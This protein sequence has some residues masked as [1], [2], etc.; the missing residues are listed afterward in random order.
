MPGAATW[1]VRLATQE[2]RFGLVFLLVGFIAVFLSPMGFLAQVLMG[3]PIFEEAM[4]FGLAVLLT[5]HPAARTLWLRLPVAW[6]VGAGFGVMEHYLTYPSEPD[7][8]F[9]ERCAFHGLSTGASVV[10]HR[11]LVG[12]PEPALRW[13]STIPSVVLHYLNNLAAVVIGLSTLIEGGGEAEVL[14]RSAWLPF[15]ILPPLAALHLV[16]P[17]ARRPMAAFVR[18]FVRFLARH[19]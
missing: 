18:P 12:H 19:I 11:V 6:L 14:E 3:A 8:L 16:A 17:V 13:G 4:K 2:A 10:L 9:A 7:W 5:S 15:A 1:W